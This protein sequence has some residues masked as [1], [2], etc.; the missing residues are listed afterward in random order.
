MAGERG[1]TSIFSWGKRS[2]GS[3]RRVN[4]RLREES[5]VEKTFDLVQSPKVVWGVAI[6]LAFIVLGS[7]TVIWSREQPLVAVGRVM[8]ETRLVRLTMSAEDKALTEAARDAARKSTPRTYVA[9][10]TYFNEL[11]TSMESLPR[12]LASATAIADVD[13]KLREQFRLTEASLA[14]LRGELGEGAEPSQRWTTRV[15]NF[16]TLLQGRPL[17]DEQTFQ[18]ATT[19][20]IGLSVRLLIGDTQKEVLRTDVLSVED[21]RLGDA[22]DSIARDAGFGVG[23]LRQLVVARVLS[24]PQPTFRFDETQTTADQNLAAANVPPKFRV[25]SE[26]QPIFRRGEVLTSTAYDLYVA[27]MK[28]FNQRADWWRVWLQWSSLSAAVVAI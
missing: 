6:L 12:A 26:G 23:P 13:P 16:I 18:R 24:S 4:I 28:H 20:G 1:R 2:P 11:K 10:Q 22:I 14:A 19:E 17:L 21:G 9:D 7:L 15:V 8:N 25:T 27:E 3:T 5:L